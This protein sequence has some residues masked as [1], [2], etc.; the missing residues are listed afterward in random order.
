MKKVIAILLSLVTLTSMSA[1]S[2]KSSKSENSST[3][4]QV[5]TTEPAATTEAVRTAEPVKASEPSKLI[6][7]MT[8]T[9]LQFTNKHGLTLLDELEKPNADPNAEHKVSIEFQTLDTAESRKSLEEYR[10][11]LT[12]KE[13]SRTLGRIQKAE[14]TGEPYQIPCNVLVD[15][16]LV[17][18][19]L[20]DVEDFSDGLPF[21]F[22]ATSYNENGESKAEKQS[23][24]TMED[25]L[26][27]IRKKDTEFGYTDEEIELEVLY[28]QVAYDALKSGN[29][30]TLPEG[31]VNTNDES[32]N[33]RNVF[34]NYRSDWEYDRDAVEAIKDSVDEISIYDEELSKQ[35]TVHVTLPPDYDKNRTYPVF[36][37]TDGIWRFGNCPE[38]R[39]CM[40]NGE[41]ASV[42]LV[43]LYYSYD[44]T[45]P[46]QE[47][48]YED[49]VINRELLL[50]FITDNLM[51]YLCENYSIDCGNSTLYGH[52]DGGVFAHYALF[53]S[54]R[55]ENQPFAHYIIGSPAFWGLYHENQYM[56]ISND[57]VLKD[58]D[59]FD[60]NETLKKSVFLCAGSQEDPD[61][62]DRYREG[63]DTTL[64]GVAKLKERLESH[65]ADLT[66][67]LYDSHHYQY[68]PEMLI[69]YLKEKY[70]YK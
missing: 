13:Y 26:E 7:K 24:D 22:T 70:P 49:L 62:A 52:S 20:P 35:F 32:I 47:M 5:Q 63:D 33:Y 31:S 46:D 45:D 21:S 55:Y 10:D 3:Y 54:D 28:V 36:F 68:I 6:N 11:E 18:R 19:L 53:N 48:R 30:E 34:H 23:F 40:E 15:G 44:V 66:Y 61:Y 2:S 42:I 60:R 51:P 4:E 56:G 50:D 29:Y 25:Y 14:E 37:L 38:L 1:C 12:E 59:Y 41:A 17:Q 65:N 8:D 9:E 58:Y 43:S 39:K 16:Y 27:Y 69:E 57:N 64:E 67:K